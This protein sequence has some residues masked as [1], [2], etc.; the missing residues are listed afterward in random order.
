MSLVYYDKNSKAG[1]LAVAIGKMDSDNAFC[2]FFK[3]YTTFPCKETQTWHAITHNQESI[4]KKIFAEIDVDGETK[5]YEIKAKTIKLHVPKDN[6]TRST[7]DTME[8]DEKGMLTLVS[9]EIRKTLK[10][11]LYH[12]TLSQD[13]QNVSMINWTD[14]DKRML[15]S[16]RKMAEEK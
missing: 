16:Y 5:H 11:K 14:E 4:N 9:K 15:E 6:G 12:I 13:L 2:P 1:A 3:K 8:I 7:D 10:A